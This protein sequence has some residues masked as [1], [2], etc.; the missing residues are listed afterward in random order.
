MIQISKDL[1]EVICQIMP[2]CQSAHRFQTQ[3]P[4]ISP[5]TADEHDKDVGHNSC[6]FLLEMGVVVDDDIDDFEEESILDV[7]FVEDLG[8]ICFFEDFCDDLGNK[9]KGAFVFRRRPH[10]QGFV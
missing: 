1:L 8:R 5:G 3:I 9:G 10:L 4:E 7:V 6:Q 2:D